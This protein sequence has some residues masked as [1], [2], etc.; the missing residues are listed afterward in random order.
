MEDGV[1]SGA[2][3]GGVLLISHKGKV[4][5]HKA[6]GFAQLIPRKIPLTINTLF[7]LASLTKPLATTTA[8]ALLIQS[9]TLRLENPVSKFIPAYKTGDKKKV[10]LAHLLSHSSGLPDW[11]PYFWA[12]IRQDKKTPGFLSSPSAKQV[13]Y[14]MANNEPLIHSPG[15]HSLYSDIGFMIL[16]EIIEKVSG[17]SLDQFCKHNIFLKLNC[18]KTFFPALGQKIT[19]RIAATEDCPWR[20]KVILGE[21]HDDNTYAMGGVSGHAGLF[22]TAQEV[23]T[24]VTD[25]LH[26]INGHGSIQAGL[27]KKLV[28][29][30]RTPKG[31][32][33]DCGGSFALGWD[34]PSLQNSSSGQFFAPSS[35]G[36]LGYTGTSIWVDH[37][38]EL[39][40]ILL[41]NRVHPTRKN[42]Q[43][44]AFRPALHDLIFQEIVG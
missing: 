30:R 3:P 11:K 13:A 28:T 16:G 15:T 33:A 19:G 22:S 37:V 32:N 23:F 4:S 20:G 18:K 17:E 2:F 7:D 5:L 6:F 8:M 21:V 26:S 36:H 43:I 12:I 10:T 27:S 42:N 31:R 9:G 34:T 41:T 35:F 38:R 14:H 25:W 29:R 24:L 40:V 44:K 1:A 39:V